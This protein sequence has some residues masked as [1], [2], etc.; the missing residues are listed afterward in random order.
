M[1]IDLFQFPLEDCRICTSTDF[2]NIFR[3]R[4][5]LRNEYSVDVRILNMHML[6]K[7]ASKRVFI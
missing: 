5:K 3:I 2:W 4:E 6:F 7:F 1:K